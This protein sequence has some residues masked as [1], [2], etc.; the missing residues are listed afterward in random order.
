MEKRDQMD[1]KSKI[2]I[3]DD[4]PTNVELLEAY[5]AQCDCEVFVASDGLETLQMAQ[6]IHPD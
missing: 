2:L 6:Q 4:N 5:L 1:R 3:A